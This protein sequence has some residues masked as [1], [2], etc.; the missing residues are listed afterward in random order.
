[1]ALILMAACEL[2]GAPA[3]F[4]HLVGVTLVVGRLLHAQGLT[5]SEGVSFGRTAGTALTW[6]VL[7]EG[8]LGALRFALSG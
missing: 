7:L 5:S 3:P 2:N 6:I 8:A 1:M 4:L